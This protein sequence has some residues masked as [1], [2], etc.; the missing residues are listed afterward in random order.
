LKA[1]STP[2]T[3]TS[4]TSALADCQVPPKT[5]K[6]MAI[7]RNILFFIFSPLFGGFW[8]CSKFPLLPYPKFP[9]DAFTNNPVNLFDS[10][11]PGGKVLLA[12]TDHFFVFLAGCS[13]EMDFLSQSIQSIH[14]IL[15]FERIPETVSGPRA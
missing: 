4:I 12:K 5:A 3:S 7:K 8:S 10:F 2:E 1:G 6:Q 15:L 13:E 14:P 11:S 9:N